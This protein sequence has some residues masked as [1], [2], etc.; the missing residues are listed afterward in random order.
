[1]KYYR[2]RAAV[3][4]CRTNILCGL[5]IR[6]RNG[7]DADGEVVAVG[8]PVSGREGERWK[9][10]RYVKLEFKEERG[11]DALDGPGPADGVCCVWGVLGSEELGG[12]GFARG[13][14]K[15]RD[16]TLVVEVGE[17]C[18]DGELGQ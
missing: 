10:A 4:A 12:E 13:R 18:G 17:R 5:S 14:E 9:R 2:R 8:D 7:G 16:F 6:G 3:V 11:L 15:D 1:M